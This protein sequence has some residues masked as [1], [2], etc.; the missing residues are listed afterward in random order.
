MFLYRERGKLKRPEIEP[1][2]SQTHCSSDV[3]ELLSKQLGHSLWSQKW[4]PERH[5]NKMRRWKKRGDVSFD[6]C[7]YIFRFNIWVVVIILNSLLLF[8][9]ACIFI[10]MY[11]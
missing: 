9:C 5:K 10:N 3:T 8:M 1:S 2:K 4:S 6:G 11:I 7:V